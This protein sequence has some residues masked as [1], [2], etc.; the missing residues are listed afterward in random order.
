MAKLA[1]GETGRRFYETGVDK[2]VLYQINGAGE[3]VDG[4]AWSG[5]TAV[6][7]SPSGAES[8]KQYADNQ[9]YLNLI[10]AEDF[11]GT[12]EAFSYPDEF[13][14]NDGSATPTPGVS[15]AQQTRK[16][17]GF[18]W[19][20][21]VGNDLEGNDH[22]YKIHIVY[23]ATAAPSEK[24]YATVNDSPEPV[25]FS[26]ELSTI[27]VFVGTFAG[28]EIK[29]TAKLTI[30]STKVDSVKLAA[31]EDLLYGTPSTDPSLPKPIDV[32]TMMA[33]TLTEA[34]PV[35]PT[36]DA[37]TDIVTIP[38]VTGVEYLVTDVVV[39]SGPY[40]PIAADVL[41][42]ARPLTGY[43]FPVPSDEDWLIEH[44]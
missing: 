18:C 14:Q 39:P 22:G 34:T 11:G 19:R 10:S 24:A 31:L 40:G 30:D 26:W 1:W 28:E 37:G 42:R 2:G 3:Y 16:P 21:L 6:T 5:L 7:A 15:I 12:I 43:K 32:I 29:P 4:V 27:P 17:F 23:G 25:P 13:E 33:T 38:T 35:A 8:N 41:V 20:T 44:A 9:V 36:Y